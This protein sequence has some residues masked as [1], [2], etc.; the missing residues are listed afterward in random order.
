MRETEDSPMLSDA[1][2][3]LHPHPLPTA[4]VAI[5]LLLTA[6]LAL[7]DAP[8]RPAPAQAPPA[9]TP[10]DWAAHQATRLQA[11]FLAWY[12]R[13]PP[14]ERI[15]WG[16]L[17]ACVVLGVLTTLDRL[18]RVR[19]KRVI[20]KAF[21]ERFQSR[22]E[23]GLLDWAK[24]LDYCELNPS[25]ASRVALA[26]LRRWGRPTADLDR[27]VSLARNVESDRLR[28]YVGTLRRISAMAPL[29]GLLG[30]LVAAGHA[31]SSMPPGASWGPLVASALA[32][33]TAGVAL[34][35][36]SLVAYDGLVGRI[37]TLSGELD[38]IGAEVVDAIVIATPSSSR[39]AAPST[40]YRADSASTGRPHSVRVEVPERIARPRGRERDRDREVDY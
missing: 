17:A 10:V 12:D 7:A 37:E 9:V 13:T 15:T 20:P 8:A 31:L 21:R 29:I 4:L 28:R 14:S 34:A 1:P 18:A 25:P 40:P 33:L 19:R 30:S 26:A 32:P 35:I 16:G 22:L 6:R 5:G 27:A 24:A 3:R 23:E 39:A 36:L 38:R 11:R 2:R